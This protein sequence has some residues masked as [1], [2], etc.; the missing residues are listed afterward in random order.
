MKYIFFSNFFLLNTATIYEIMLLIY[1]KM[2][3]QNDR[4]QL[5]NFLNHVQDKV[6]ETTWNVLGWWKATSIDDAFVFQKDT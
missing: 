3:K 6:E 1:Q 5:Y 2:V 4:E